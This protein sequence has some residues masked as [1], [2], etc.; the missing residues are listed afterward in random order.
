MKNRQ[1]DEF[2][3]FSDEYKNLPEEYEPLQNEISNKDNEISKD[4][5]A[6]FIN[7]KKHRKMKAV[8]V[9][10]TALSF[11][12]FGVIS[13]PTVLYHNPFVVDTAKL[14]SVNPM[15]NDAAQQKPKEY[16]EDTST[17]IDL[18]EQNTEINIE[19]TTVEPSNNS[20]LPEQFDEDLQVN[21]LVEVTV[22]DDSY[23]VISYIAGDKFAFRLNGKY[24]VMDAQGNVLIEP[25]YEYVSINDNTVCFIQAQEEGYY[26]VLLNEDLEKMYELSGNEYINGYG[27]NIVGIVSGENTRFLDAAN[28]YNEIFVVASNIMSVFKNGY[29]VDWNTT[30]TGDKRYYDLS[31]NSYDIWMADNPED[32]FVPT[33][34]KNLDSGKTANS[35]QTNDSQIDMDGVTNNQESNFRLP[36]NFRISINGRGADGVVYADY[37]YYMTSNINECGWVSARAVVEERNIPCLINVFTKQMICFDEI[38][39]NGGANKKIEGISIEDNYACISEDDGS[40]YRVFDLQKLCFVSDAYSYIGLN[41]LNEGIL[42]CKGSEGKYWGYLDSDFQ[43][44]SRLYDDVTDFAGDYAMVH[45]NGN[46][47]IINQNFEY[48]SEPIEGES[49]IALAPGYFAVKRSDGY[50]LIS[51]KKITQ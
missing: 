34:I 7:K 48:V 9:I 15:G 4:N 28:G 29:V 11:V 21:K 25:N 39:I 47:Y 30:L 22:Y 32:G 31:G 38:D 16:T 46:E 26:S 40:T 23:E 33:S 12:A 51:V 35:N 14:E 49:A 6:S 1:G 8:Y 2:Y 3:R 17:E 44:M 41:S 13:F 18:Q 45:I 27:E 42:I 20:E 50:H 43:L 19:E 24:G 36:D 10:A 37:G 5:N